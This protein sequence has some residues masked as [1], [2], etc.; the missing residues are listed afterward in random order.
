MLTLNCV[1][2]LINTIYSNCKMRL[3][4]LPLCSQLEYLKMRDVFVLKKTT[5]FILHEG[6]VQ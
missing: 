6:P 3:D 2:I 4:L 5:F 1:Q